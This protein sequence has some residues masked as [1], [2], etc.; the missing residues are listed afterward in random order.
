MCILILKKT[1][2]LVRSGY[3]VKILPCN[4]NRR[5]KNDISQRDVV[6]T[7]AFLVVECLKSSDRR[8]TL[9]RLLTGK[10]KVILN[11]I[12]T[13]FGGMEDGG[14]ARCFR[15]AFRGRRGANLG[16]ALSLQLRIMP[17]LSKERITICTN[18]LPSL[19]ESD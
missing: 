4:I 11:F 5:S 6:L 13:I 9:T 8:V 2:L 18:R 19:L 16:F 7:I 15:R 14:W 1:L 10:I 3:L 12:L 17:W